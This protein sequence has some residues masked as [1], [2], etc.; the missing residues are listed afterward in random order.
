MFK[1]FK[2]GKKVALP[3]EVCEWLRSLEIP[4]VGLES[5][6]FPISKFHDLQISRFQSS[7]CGPTAYK[8]TLSPKNQW[9]VIKAVK[10]GYKQDRRGR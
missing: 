5:N 6:I 7:E 1:L 3:K 8:W 2:N 10:Y 9:K 4:D